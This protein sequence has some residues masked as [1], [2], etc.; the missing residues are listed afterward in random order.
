MNAPSR[1]TPEDPRHP[2]WCSRAD[3]DSVKR[4]GSD[5]KSSPITVE[6]TFSKTTLWLSKHL[7]EP[8]TEGDTYVNIRITEASPDGEVTG[9]QS[10][11]YELTEASQFGAVLRILAGRGEDR[12]AVG[13]GEWR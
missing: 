10:Y 1:A 13:P 2:H 5:H 7:Y 11:C 8:V 9:V 12:T 6:G 3:C 4:H